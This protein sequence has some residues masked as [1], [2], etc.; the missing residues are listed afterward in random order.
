MREGGGRKKTFYLK[1]LKRKIRQRLHWMC[2]LLQEQD[3]DADEVPRVL[4]MDSL[5]GSDIHSTIFYLVD[6]LVLSLLLKKYITYEL[7][8][9]K[10]NVLPKGEEKDPAAPER[11]SV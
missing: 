9:E 11:P 4:F 2:G 5:H 8:L 3:V 10:K 7:I 6:L 1:V